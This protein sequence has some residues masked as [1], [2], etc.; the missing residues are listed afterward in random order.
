[1]LG[2]SMD[3][4]SRWIMAIGLWGCALYL[5]Q[6]GYRSLRFIWF[7][8]AL[9]LAFS[10]LFLVI[11]DCIRFAAVPFTTM[12][13]AIVFPRVRSGKPEPNYRLA[14]YYVKEERWDDAE[15]EYRTIL[16]FHRREG[17]AYLGLIELLMVEGRAEEARKVLHQSRRYLKSDPE[18]LSEIEVRWD[19][20]SSQIETI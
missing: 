4:I 18:S 15:V 14:E 6:H 19:Q 12:I 5:A 17:K 7:V 11:K 2:G 9:I 1:M 3:R 13:D 20:Q 10:G 8:P 16:K